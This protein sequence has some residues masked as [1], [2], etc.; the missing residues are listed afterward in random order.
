MHL[1]LRVS[2]YS[3]ASMYNVTAL[4]AV[5]QTL[6]YAAARALCHGEIHEGFGA[7]LHACMH[8]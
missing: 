3:L 2:S 6:D 7:W 1:P 8:D 5:T 4:A